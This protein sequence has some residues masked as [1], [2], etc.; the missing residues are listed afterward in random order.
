[1][2]LIQKLLKHLNE[3]TMH[4]LYEKTPK[5]YR[6]DITR[7]ISKPYYDTLF[8]YYKTLPDWIQKE[9]VVISYFRLLEYYPIGLTLQQKQD[10]LN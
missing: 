2:G 10:Q 7:R 6:D 8:S 9:P 5:S 1:M 3:D 4:E